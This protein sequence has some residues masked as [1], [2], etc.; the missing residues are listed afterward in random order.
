VVA[1]D[2]EQVRAEVI[3]A[4]ARNRAGADIAVPGRTGGVGENDRAAGLCGGLRGG[5][6]AVVVELRE[7]TGVCG[8][9]RVGGCGVVVVREDAAAVVD[10]DGVAGRARGVEVQIVVVGKAWR[11]RGIVDDAGTVDVEGD[12]RAARYEVKGGR[13]GG[14]LDRIDRSVIGNRRRGRSAVVGEQRRVVRHRPG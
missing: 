9:D 5:A 12:S 8:G 6:G 13:T 10:D 11:E 7:G 14:E 3:I 4:R 1:A 2:R